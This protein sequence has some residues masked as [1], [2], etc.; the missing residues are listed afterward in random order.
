MF[1]GDIENGD[2]YGGEKDNQ[3]REKSKDYVHGGIA[4]G[5]EYHSYLEKLN[6]AF[7]V[8]WTGKLH[9]YFSRLVCISTCRK[10][11]E[12]KDLNKNVKTELFNNEKN[13]LLGSELHLT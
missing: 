5:T 4:D 13:F 6:E 9:L 8:E 2:H 11:K 12:T 10:Y 7:Q 3:D 1:I